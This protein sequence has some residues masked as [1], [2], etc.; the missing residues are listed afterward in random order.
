MI[1]FI[2][3]LFSM[4]VFLLVIIF[5]LT[6]YIVYLH[7]KLIKRDIRIDSLLA[8]MAE[9]GI[10]TGFREI[11]DE[12]LFDQEILS[13]IYENNDLTK[14]YLHYTRQKS[15]AENIMKEG[16]RFAD[17]FYKTAFP[18][19]GDRLDLAIK[20]QSKRYYGDYIIVISISEEIIRYYNNAITAAGIRN[21]HYE[22]IL[23]ERPPEKN[24]NSDTVYTL[25]SKY[26]KGIINHRTGEITANEGFDPFYSSPWFEKNLERIRDKF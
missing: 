7:L 4:Q 12:K 19:T 26:I 15:D 21:C 5:I 3:T 9:A 20:H 11:K 22:N 10:N 18:V 16:F 8:K 25:P 2:Q 13:F 24:D 14:I 6:G 1:Q 23:T 17:S